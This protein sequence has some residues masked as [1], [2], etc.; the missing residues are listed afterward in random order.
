[1]RHVKSL[2]V[3]VFVTALVIMGVA[4]SA[5]L[6]IFVKDADSDGVY[7]EIALRSYFETG[8]GKRPYDPGDPTTERGDY[9]YVITRPRHLYNLSRLQS[10]GVFGDKTYFQLGLVG[11]AGNESGLPYCYASDVSRDLVPYLDLSGSDYS[12]ETIMSIGSESTP[13]YGEFDGQNLEIRNAQIYADP[14]DAG[15]FGYTA[16]GS[17]VHNLFLSNITINT[18]GYE[19]SKY[20]GLYG[21]D[22][23]LAAGTSIIYNSDTENPYT[24]GEDHY[25][26]G[27]FDADD[28]WDWVDENGYLDPSQ[29]DYTGGLDLEASAPTVSYSGEKSGFT[30]KMLVSGGFLVP[31]GK[32]AKVCLKNVYDYFYNAKKD[33]AASSFPLAASSSVSLCVSQV[34]NEGLE[35][36]NIILGLRFTFVLQSP[37]D[38]VIRMSVHSNLEHNNNIGLLI[39]HCDGTVRNCYVYNG[40]FV[41]NDGDT[42]TSSSS[43]T[44]GALSNSSSTGIIGLVGDS[45]YNAVGAESSAGASSGLDVGVLDFTNVYNDIISGDSAFTSALVDSTNAPNYG[46]YYNPNTSSQYEP[47][48]R[49]N[50]TGYVTQKSQTVAFAGRHVINNTDLGIFTLATDYY[51][52]EKG[53]NVLDRMDV[54]ERVIKCAP[55]LQKEDVAYVDSG[56]SSYYVYYATG[57]YVKG[58]AAPKDGNKGYSTNGVIFTDF[59]DSM[60]TP[61]PK[62]MH[63]GYHFP[64]PDEVTS[65]SF[66]QRELYQNYF[67]RFK[68]DGRVAGNY[69]LAGLDRDSAGG[70][71]LSKYFNYKLI[72]KKYVPIPDDDPRCGVTILD[73]KLGEPV[74]IDS[75]SCSF[76][77]PDS[78]DGSEMYCL[79]NADA[80]HPAANVIN[81]EI[82]TEMANV[83]VI[84]APADRDNAGKTKSA[85]IGVY[86]YNYDTSLGDRTYDREFGENETDSY[87][88]DANHLNFITRKYRDPDYAFFMP[89]DDN[90]AYFDYHVNSDGVGE[91]GT[92]SDG[93]EASFEPATYETEATIPV[94]GADYFQDTVSGGTAKKTRLFA[95]TFKLPQGRYY[96]SSA[97]GSG[98]TNCGKAKIFYVAAQGQTAGQINLSN[99]LFTDIVDRVDFIQR[100]RSTISDIQLNSPDLWR[101]FIQLL[102]YKSSDERSHFADAL[103]KVQFVYSDGSF[104]VTCNEDDKPANYYIGNMSS[105]TVNTYRS[106][107]VDGQDNIPVVLFGEAYPSSKPDVIYY[108]AVAP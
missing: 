83:T 29:Y 21:N 80:G 62:Q 96:L 82:K 10:L 74:G 70:S 4:A 9:P 86:K 90:L 65:E 102:Y 53:E 93:S 79:Y 33:A 46:Y 101:C 24:R 76:T 1:M 52:A 98:N 84:A 75:L 91:I 37:E 20:M 45:V 81:F 68:L 26:N 7:G 89:N 64:H 63:L 35:H 56:K 72:D 92:Y 13:F 19:K 15:L 47:Y 12:H 107:K 57:E 28:Y 60:N 43:G 31:D 34:D 100:P 61:T 104:Y 99:S 88:Y 11:L 32:G 97:T 54:D 39:G 106:N 48:L 2:L 50:T 94:K 87:A 108:P 36:S 77:T 16:Q 71:F 23:A 27:E 17:S 66:A 22:A 67:F 103:S 3:P 6:A 38:T 25:E 44:Y 40:Q 42:I 73:Y 59:V 69:Y 14:Q 85:S 30:Y 55:V 51:S 49:K 95:H 41:M 18:L 78:S 8:N 58:S 5:T 105:V